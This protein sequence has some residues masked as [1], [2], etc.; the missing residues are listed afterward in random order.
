MR[1]IVIM[2]SDDAGEKAREQIEKKCS[3]T[4]NIQHIRLS[5]NDIADMTPE[6]INQEI[7]AKI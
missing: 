4:Y 1:L 3:R 6:E 5:K 2:D 7:K